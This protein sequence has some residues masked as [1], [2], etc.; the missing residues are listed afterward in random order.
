MAFPEN[1]KRLNQWHV[2]RNEDGR[3][4]PYCVDRRTKARSNDPTTWSSYEEAQQACG[5]GFQLA[6]TLGPISDD[7][8]QVTGFDF[9][10]AFGESGEMRPWAKEV[11]EIIRDCS[12]IE[13]SPSGKGFKGL[14]VGS[15]TDGAR[16]SVS[17][18]PG[19]QAL[20]VFDHNRFWAVTGEQVDEASGFGCREGSQEAVSRVC[21][22]YLTP[23]PQE[24]PKA[25]QAV[26]GASN[27]TSLFSESQ[28][29]DYRVRGWLS[30]VSPPGAGERN[31]VLF[32]TAGGLY[33]FGLSSDMVLS[34]LSEFNSSLVDPLSQFEIN[35]IVESARRNGTPRGFKGENR[36]Y[37][38]QSTDDILDLTGLDVLNVSEE[39]RDVVVDSPDETNPESPEHQIPMEMI[40]GTGFIEE[41]TKWVISNQSEI[42]PELAMSAAIHACSLGISRRFKDDSVHET[43]PNMY[44]VALARTGAGK[45]LPRRCI[46]KS[47]TESGYEHLSGPGTIDSG[48]GLV[49]M[50]VNKP[51]CSMLL[52]ECGSLFK[53]VGD[54]NVPMHLRKASD[55]LK[56]LYT[57]GTK[58]G[59][60]LRALANGS[61]GQNKAV[62]YP[63]L[64]I[65]GSATPCQVLNSI[66]EES[67]SDGL[68]GRFVMF[69]GTNAPERKRVLT[70]NEMP[71]SI[72]DWMRQWDG[73]EASGSLPS[74]LAA[75][76]TDCLKVASRTM[77]A[78]ET[79]CEYQ[80][81]VATRSIKSHRE[82]GNSSTKVAVWARAAEKAAKLAM[83][84]A[85]SRAVGTEFVIEK[86]D[87]DRAIQMVNH[88]TRRVIMAYNL[89]V[90]TQYGKDRETFLNSMPASGYATKPFVAK[91]ARQIDPILRDRILADCI[92]AKEITVSMYNGELVYKRS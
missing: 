77:G 88:L 69:F 80:E 5:D 32:K 36:D 34:Y 44:I 55:F 60:Q 31:N 68:M 24:A 17:M 82:G 39:I 30:K 67:M 73:V 76:F 42:Q 41:F 89:G 61:E 49:T 18:G 56:T 75:E 78:A 13:V 15:K 25:L 59:L 86:E 4:I 7:S 54:R 29:L 92:A 65:M 57:S 91:I 70:L 6:F 58:K 43:T 19:G 64:H 83:I 87:M 66:S 62:D 1:L 45:E 22:E 71:D 20:E 90:N 47:L 8:I 40:E 48:P 9:D 26:S 10:N 79:L 27:G 28:T 51:S 63:H 52:D 23:K 14:V 85:A 21:R 35:Q 84:F 16:C 53:G 50:I 72:R 12:Y 11:Y 3:K 74:D 38:R 2:W 37:V 46:E 81:E 33:G